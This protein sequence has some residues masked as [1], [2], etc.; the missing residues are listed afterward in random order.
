MRLLFYFDVVFI[1]V[2]I[3]EYVNFTDVDLDGTLNMFSMS[4][5]NILINFSLNNLILLFIAT[6][7]AFFH[8]NLSSQFYWSVCFD[9][10]LNCV[11]CGSII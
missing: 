10:D 11:N 7:S 5:Y 4:V 1:E 6:V 8:E 9:N 2:S 3:Q